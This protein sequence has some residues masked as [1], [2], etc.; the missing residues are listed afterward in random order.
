MTHDLEKFSTKQRVSTV[1]AYLNEVER[2]CKEQ[3]DSD[4]ESMPKELTGL[5]I[6]WD[7]VIAKSG[8]KTSAGG[9]ARLVYRSLAMDSVMDVI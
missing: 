9:A 3:F 4:W 8:V 7:V 2:V 5:P 6:R 1:R